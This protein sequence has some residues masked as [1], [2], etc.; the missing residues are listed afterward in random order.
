MAPQGGA[1]AAS[2]AQPGVRTGQPSATPVAPAAAELQPTLSSR[3]LLRSWPTML[4]EMGKQNSQALLMNNNI[5]KLAESVKSIKFRA[6]REAELLQTVP[7][8][9]DTKIT[10]L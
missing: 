10:V 6:D 7:G 3:T 8:V 9:F 1:S 4:T 5:D 2:G